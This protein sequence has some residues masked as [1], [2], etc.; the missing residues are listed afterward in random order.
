[1]ATRIDTQ[2]QRFALVRI[3]VVHAPILAAR[4][5]QQVHAAAVGVFVTRGF[6]GVL[7]LPYECV[8]QCHCC[9]PVTVSLLR[10]L[11]DT[12]KDTV[13]LTVSHVSW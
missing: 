5:H 3:G 11:R 7:H 10:Y 8:C 13:L 4:L 6:A 9:P 2:G 12:V 1:M